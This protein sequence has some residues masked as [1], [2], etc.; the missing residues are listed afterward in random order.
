MTLNDY[1]GSILPKSFSVS[2]SEIFIFILLK[3]KVL[4]DRNLKSKNDQV[5][6]SLV[7]H[8]KYNNNN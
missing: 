8:K 3:G 5:Q 7:T 4:S 6:K 1:H 2:H